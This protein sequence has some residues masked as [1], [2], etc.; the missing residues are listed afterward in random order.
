MG[1]CSNCSALHNILL[2]PKERA[3]KAL[4]LNEDN[5]DKEGSDG[6]DEN[7][8]ERNENDHAY[9]TSQNED[10]KPSTSSKGTGKDGKT[11][12]ARKAEVQEE[13]EKG[14]MRTLSQII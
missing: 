11:K 4:T 2:C 5:D 9:L 10:P 7:E 3:S 8:Y 13:S 12:Q 14:I 6:S 1:I